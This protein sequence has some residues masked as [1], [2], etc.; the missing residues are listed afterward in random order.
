MGVAAVGSLRLLRL[1]ALLAASFSAAA[2]VDAYAP[3]PA[4]CASGGG[5]CEAVAASELGQLLGGFLPALGI[6]AYTLVLVGSLFSLTR[7][8]ALLTA[9]LGGVG[10]LSL[11][12]IQAWQIGSFCQLCL[13]VDLSAV[14]VAALALIGLRAGAQESA[15]GSLALWAGLYVLAVGCP[16]AYAASQP[17]PVPQGVRSLWQA[18]KINVVEFSDFQCPYCRKMHPVLRGALKSYGDRVHVD[19]R[20]YP[21]SSHAHAAGAAAAFICAHAQGK[22]EAMA[23]ELFAR[24]D[25]SEQALPEI[26][27]HVG[28]DVAVF[29][30]CVGSSETK[31]RVADDKELVASTGMQ[32]L[33]TVW[34]GDTVVLGFDASAGAA[35]YARALRL[36]ATGDPAATRFTPWLLVLGLAIGL[37][38]LAARGSKKDA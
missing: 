7:R 34:I 19:R 32:G 16:P 6:V 3:V 10:G 38:A 27:A 24:E 5:G 31:Q 13:G 14:V 30:S 9:V 37:L 29:G 11:L 1:F 26:A 18:G 35:P 33:P 8:A 2:A 36:A 20:S 25:I 12:A 17:K 21:L 28:L 23:D 15:R 22:G 4:F